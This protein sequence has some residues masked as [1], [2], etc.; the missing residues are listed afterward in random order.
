M[1]R[2]KDHRDGFE[3]IERSKQCLY[4]P[5]KLLLCGFSASAQTKFKSLLG[6]LGLEGVPLVW[7]TRDEAEQLVKELFSHADG[8]GAGKDS[9]LPRAIIAGG[10]AQ[11]ELHRLMSG[12]RQ[13]GMQKSLWAVLTPTSEDWTLS[14][15]LAALAAEAKAMAGKKKKE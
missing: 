12:C 14:R 4:G 7:A 9:R 1:T 2:N 6:M 8:S 5:R 13:G 11:Q 10:I 15:L 3:K